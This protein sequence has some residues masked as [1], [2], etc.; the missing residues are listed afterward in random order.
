MTVAKPQPRLENF[1]NF[2]SSNFLMDEGLGYVYAG[3]LQ[4]TNSI[5]FSTFR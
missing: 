2:D 3:C 4:K 1:R 5:T